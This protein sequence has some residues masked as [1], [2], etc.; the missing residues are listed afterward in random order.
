MTSAKKFFTLNLFML[1][2]SEL[3]DTIYRELLVPGY[4][5]VLKRSRAREAEGSAQRPALAEH[6][7]LRLYHLP[8]ALPLKA[9][10]ASLR[11][12]ITKC[13]YFTRETTHVACLFL[14]RNC[15]IYFTIFCINNPHAIPAKAPQKPSMP[16]RI[17]LFHLHF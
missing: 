7:A 9:L 13:L 15:I 16:F 5:V 17:N 10:K 4:L 6:G 2:I 1:I 14:S 3:P 8:F 11:L 12:E